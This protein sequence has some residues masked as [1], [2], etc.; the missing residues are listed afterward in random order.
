[1]IDGSVRVMIAVDA[2]AGDGRIDRSLD[3]LQS[4]EPSQTSVTQGAFTLRL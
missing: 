1:V 4:I 2:I 3:D